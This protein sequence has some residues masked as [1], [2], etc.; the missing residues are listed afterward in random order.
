[1]DC[2]LP[3]TTKT[4][5]EEVPA[6]PD[7]WMPRRRFIAVSRGR[8]RHELEQC[9]RNVLIRRQY[10]PPQLH[11]AADDPAG[12]LTQEIRSGNLTADELLSIYCSIV[13]KQTGSYEATARR[14]KLDRRTVKTRVEAQRNR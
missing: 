6:N 2:L 8:R 1:M 4:R 10:H 13:Y 12:E 14:V 5:S 7:V 9:V 11:P 3:H